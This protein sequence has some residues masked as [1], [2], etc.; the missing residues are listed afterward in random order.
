MTMPTSHRIEVDGF[1]LHA[2][3]DGQGRPVIFG[4]GFLYDW[5][6]WQE[7]MEMLAPDHRVV[8][9]DARGHGS[10]GLPDGHWTMEDQGDDYVR[11]MDALGIDQAVVVGLSMGGMAAL[12][13]ALRH[14]RRVRGLG[15]IDTS[16]GGETLVRRT[17]YRMLSLLARA[18]G[19]RPWLL[20]EASKVMYGATFRR[21]HPERVEQWMSGMSD[22]DPRIIARTLRPIVKRGSVVSRLPTSAAPAL[23][24]V[25]DE[26][27]TTPP[28]ESEVMAER[29]PSARLVTLGATGHMS[30]LERPEQTAGL[31]REFLHEI[32]W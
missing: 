3:D 6:M 21:H 7:P 28:R 8:A 12:R 13:M 24:I 27:Q 17:R 31:I 11:V 14:P 25:G 5:R 15:L 19:I 20:K 10:S 29:L 32:G 30:P 18:F 1:A 23:V 2:R 4:H 9:F 16:A 26:D 22:Y